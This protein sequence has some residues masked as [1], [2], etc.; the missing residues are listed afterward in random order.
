MPDVKIVKVDDTPPPSM[1]KNMPVK[2]VED[3]KLTSGGKKTLKTFPR[4]I[5][6]TSK[7]KPVKN[8]SRAPPSKKHTIRL[9]TDKAVQ[10]R[11]KTIKKRISKMSDQKVKDV[12]MK[13]GLIK[14]P[15]MPASMVREIVEGGMIA[16]FVSSA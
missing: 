8:P 15:Q 6:K 12:A 16:G 13:A 11:R 3:P 2:P 1:P 5:L 9:I 7:I 10:H 14:N 4:G